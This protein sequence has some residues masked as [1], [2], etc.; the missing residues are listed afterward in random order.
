MLQSGRLAKSVACRRAALPRPLALRSFTVLAGGKGAWSGS[1][2]KRWTGAPIT[3]ENSSLRTVAPAIPSRPIFMWVENIFNRMDRQRLSE[4]GPDRTAAEFVLR[5]GGR[6]KYVP[7][8]GED[9][10][11]WVQKDVELPKFQES[12]P[13]K[14]VAVDLGGITVTTVGMEH[15]R[16]LKHLKSINLSDCKYLTDDGLEYLLQGNP[17]LQQVDLTGSG[18]SEAGVSKLKS[19]LKGARVIWAPSE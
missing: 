18:V 16:N 19:A 11:D 3:A 13:M 7:F 4:A 14:L 12:K 1:L 9:V 6:L 5:M 8:D 2:L 17:S 15:I 10:S